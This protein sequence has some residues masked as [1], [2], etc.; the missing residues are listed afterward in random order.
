MSVKIMSMVWESGLPKHQKMALLAYADHANDEGG[1]IFPGEEL[2]AEK[3]S[4]S[5]GNMRRITKTLV[6]AGYLERVTPGRRGQRAQYRIVL[7]SLAAQIEFHRVERERVSAGIG[8]AAHI[9]HLTP[10]SE[11]AQE[12]EIAAH[13][14]P[15]SRALVQ[16]Q[17]RM[18]ATPNVIEPS[19]TVSEPPVSGSA[20][21]VA[22]GA[23][24][25][26][27][28]KEIHDGLVFAL[29]DA[30][31][32]EREQ[33]SEPQWGKLHRAAKDL[34]GVA[35][36]EEIPRAVAIYRINFSGASISPNAI[37]ANWAEL[38]VARRPLSQR[39]I[40]RAAERE[41]SAAAMQSIRER[42]G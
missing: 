10:E 2:M 3:T 13:G 29:A 1:S 25:E 34:E 42:S 27:S 22:A 30:L 32:W 38:Q 31:G 15:D 8:L 40:V 33:I 35:E 7:E 36:P 20:A 4:D 41:E 11:G 18:E 6:D 37:A 28:A 14:G 5:P 9:A 17:A 12:S 26:R 24:G 39:E 19:R 16:P 23:A 21:I